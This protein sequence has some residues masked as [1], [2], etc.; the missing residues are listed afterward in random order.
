MGEKLKTIEDV[1]VP[2]S[3]SSEQYAE[4]KKAFDDV[5]KKCKPEIIGGECGYKINDSELEKAY[6]AGKMLQYQ[7]ENGEWVDFSKNTVCDDFKFQEHLNYRIKPKCKWTAPN[8]QE[9][10][11]K[12]S[13]ICGDCEYN[14]VKQ[15][16][17]LSSEQYAEQTKAFK[18]ALASD[19]VYI[20]NYDYT[21]IQNYIEAIRLIAE[22]VGTAES[23]CIE[24][25][26]RDV[27]NYLYDLV[28]GDKN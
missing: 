19:Y 11:C 6:K 16:R 1:K 14:T 25:L 4:Q 18:D 3:L 22:K 21:K 27:G 15:L 24:Q 20:R 2:R 12:P 28:K 7:K 8:G 9:Y 10:E 17:S 13:I 23:D 26:A 5:I